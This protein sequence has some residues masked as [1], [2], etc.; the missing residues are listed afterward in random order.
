MLYSSVLR[1]HLA[2][3]LASKVVRRTCAVGPLRTWSRGSAYH[4]V[5]RLGAR[6]ALRR[7]GK[8]VTSGA[9]RRPDCC[10]DK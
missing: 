2:Q 3:F 1:G 9:R 7:L 6:A 5:Q 10:P 4:R 8:R